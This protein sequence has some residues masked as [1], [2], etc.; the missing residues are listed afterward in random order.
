MKLTACSKRRATLA[1]ALLISAFPPCSLAQNNV[2]SLRPVESFLVKR[3]ETA[4]LKLQAELRPGFHVNSNQPADDYLIPLKL[5]WNPG[6]LQVEQIVYPQP[7]SANLAFSTKP[8]LIFSGRFEIVTR[9]KT[10]AGAAAG[11]V[12]LTGKLRY[13]ACN[14]KECL[15]PKTLDI[16]IPVSIR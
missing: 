3:G 16:K 9:F 6:P 12:P 14:E 1:A 5:T 13:Q 11:P 4:P 2:L 8:V 7:Q 10:P 15:P